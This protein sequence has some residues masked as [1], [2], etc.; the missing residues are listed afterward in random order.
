MEGVVPYLAGFAESDQANNPDV[1][2]PPVPYRDAEGVYI[3]A[4]CID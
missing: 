4:K 1:Q 3:C 2:A